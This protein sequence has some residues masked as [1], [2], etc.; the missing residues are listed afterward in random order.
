MSECMT[1][2]REAAFGNMDCVEILGD[3]FNDILLVGTIC[4]DFEAASGV[5][6]NRNRKTVVIGL[7]WQQWPLEWLHSMDTVKLVVYVIF[8]VFMLTIQLSW[9]LVLASMEHTLRLWA[10]L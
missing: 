2:I 9:D 10:R 5:I 7:G 6:L 4:R 8:S 3:T 1:N